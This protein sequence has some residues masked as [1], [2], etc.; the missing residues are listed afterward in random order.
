MIRI[1]S[2]LSSRRRPLPAVLGLALVLGAAAP[3]LASAT[4][5]ALEYGPEAEARFIAHCSDA[6]PAAACR[7]VAERLQD[8][9]G[10]PGFLLVASAVVAGPSAEAA[11]AGLSR[12]ALDG[13][14][15]ACGAAPHG[16][17]I[18]ASTR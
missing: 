13:A 8:R 4:D 11:P 9:L 2:P 12:V 3:G 5:F 15:V 7:C 1:R 18:T 17:T 16:A 10:Y 6:A 14:R